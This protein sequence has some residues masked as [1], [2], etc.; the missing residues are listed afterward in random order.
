MPGTDDQERPTRELAEQPE[1][2][3]VSIH[4]R[5]A[6]SENIQGLPL[7]PP[8]EVAEK[9]AAWLAQRDFGE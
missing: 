5:G 3:N 1:A 6:P 2:N 7:G 4:W 8:D 9:P